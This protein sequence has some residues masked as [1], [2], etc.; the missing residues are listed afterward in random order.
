MNTKIIDINYRYY[1][2]ITYNNDIT[3]LYRLIDRN[4]DDKTIVESFNRDSFLIKASKHIKITSKTE[5]L[6][7]SI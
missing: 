5:C 4:N 6:I 3:R 1:V 2:I 7:A